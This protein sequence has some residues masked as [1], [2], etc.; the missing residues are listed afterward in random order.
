MIGLRKELSRLKGLEFD[1]AIIPD[2]SE[3]NDA[4]PIALNALYVAV[5]R[6]RHAIL[7]G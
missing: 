5:S 1:V 6:P 2:I 7:L 3:F 4:D